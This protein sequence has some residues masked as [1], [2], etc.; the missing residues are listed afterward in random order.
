[1][2]EKKLEFFEKDQIDWKETEMRTLYTKLNEVKKNNPALHNGEF[3]ASII[4]I[5]NN[6]PYKLYS[7]LR[8]KRWNQGAIPI[9]FSPE[10]VYIKLRGLGGEYTYIFYNTTVKYIPNSNI[11][12]NLTITCNLALDL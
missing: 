9:N 5:S 12:L 1:M 11:I 3:G 4:R 2:N 8:K 6:E 10:D 7:V